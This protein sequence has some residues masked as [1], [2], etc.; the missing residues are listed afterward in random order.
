[1]SGFLHCS[2]NKLLCQKCKP[3]TGSLRLPSH[4]HYACSA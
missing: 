1:M 4:L 3:A 2:I